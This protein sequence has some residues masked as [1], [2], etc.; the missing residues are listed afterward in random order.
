MLVLKAVA[1]IGLV[2]SIVWFFNAPGFEPALACIGSLITLGGLAFRDKNAKTKSDAVRYSSIT[3]AP[4]NGQGG[5]GGGG[6]AIG[7]G[8]KVIGGFGGAGGGPRGGRGGDGGGGDAVGEGSMV[9]GGDGG[10]GGRSDGRGGRGGASPLKRVSPELLKS[11]GLTGNEGY[12]QGGSGESSPEYVRRL[13]VLN[14]LSAEYL[15]AN[16]TGHMEPMHGVLM[17]PIAYVNSRLSEN[18]ETFQVEL[19]DNG[20]DFLFRANIQEERLDA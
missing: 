12:G 15:S 11:F 13:K 6:N 3:S 19:I 8:T 1:W 9:I 16:P 10:G 2:L 4:A 14:A 20:T 5:R 17:P 7:K 18:G